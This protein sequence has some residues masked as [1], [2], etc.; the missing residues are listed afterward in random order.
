LIEPLGFELDD[1]RLRRA[2][3]DYH[4]WASVKKHSNW[5][6]FI[7]NESPAKL[8]A[9][10]TRGDRLHTEPHYQPGDYLLFGPETRGL[11]TSL[12]N[13][14]P[15]E[16]WLRIPQQPQSRSLNLANAAA[17]VVYEAWRQLKF[18]GGHTPGE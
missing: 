12:L 16:Q 4:E 14:L 17:V 5:D 9:L 15:A 7:A 10:T 11:P 2:G 8:Y 13:Q 18:A 3:L 1:R 6:T